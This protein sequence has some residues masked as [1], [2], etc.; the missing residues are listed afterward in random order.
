MSIDQ[1]GLHFNPS[2]SA[3][4]Y[5]IPNLF[6]PSVGSG[7]HSSAA[8]LTNS[9][10][11][12]LK[13]VA[14]HQPADFVSP[15]LLPEAQLQFG[16]SQSPF[17]SM[18]A[19][20]FAMRTKTITSPYDW[21]EHSSAPAASAALTNG[22]LARSEAMMAPPPPDASAIWPPRAQRPE[23]A[24]LLDEFVTR[25][26]PDQ[27]LSMLKQLNSHHD[28]GFKLAALD[29]RQ[30]IAHA[31]DTAA[32]EFELL[33]GEHQTHGSQR[34]IRQESG[35]QQLQVD[36]LAESLLNKTLGMH[37]E[38]MMNSSTKQV[39][40]NKLVKET[41]KLLAN[42]FAQ[43]VKNLDFG[44]ESTSG[45]NNRIE[46]TN[47]TPTTTA[48]TTS[49]TTSRPN[50]TNKQ[51]SPSQ[52]TMNADNAAKLIE[53]FMLSTAGANKNNTPT[54]RT[55]DF[56]DQSSESVQRDDERLLI[57]S[58]STDRPAP[59]VLLQPSRIGEQISNLDSPTGLNR[60]EPVRISTA[61]AEPA[62]YL[63]ANKGNESMVGS[64]AAATPTNSTSRTA[65][66]N[67][68][69]PMNNLAMALNVMN[70]VLLNQRLA[71]AQATKVVPNMTA[72]EIDGSVARPAKQQHIRKKWRLIPGRQ[73]TLDVTST[74]STRA[75]MSQLERESNHRT[76]NNLLRSNASLL[77]VGQNATRKLPLPSNYH[78]QPIPM[79]ATTTHHKQSRKNPS[80]EV[81]HASRWN[82]VLQHITLATG[83]AR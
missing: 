3:L 67:G 18:G 32:R 55:P 2:N 51:W 27:L 42:S 5:T 65:T 78:Y 76:S 75:P 16:R 10:Q 31:P 49:T 1:S 41:S 54:I 60:Q 74:T 15:S 57:K 82:D 21:A 73:E 11:L 77:V 68:Q 53:K 79:S 25:A 8:A 63:A 29:P 64:I 35:R 81:E 13:Q 52:I 62:I 56:R 47:S 45:A 23:D 40:D 48:T 7:A 69:Q 38:R 39:E 59:T 66:E 22:S 83:A 34:I 58:Q 71:Q 43:L 36:E 20:S 30:P 12:M 61:V 50:A 80:E 70:M 6:S 9:L 4:K 46:K 17:D 14:E 44:S 72:I 24:K 33:A 19:N 37:L 26:S 28:S